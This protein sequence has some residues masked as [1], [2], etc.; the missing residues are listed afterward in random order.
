MF[1]LRG[2]VDWKVAPPPESYVKVLIPNVMVFGGWAFGQWLVHE[3]RALVM[4]LCLY[5]KRSL[6]DDLS[7]R[8][9]RSQQGDG[10]L[11]TRKR[12]LPG[13]PCQCLISE[14]DVVIITINL[15]FF[16][17]PHSAVFCYSSHNWLRRKT[18]GSSISAKHL[19]YKSTCFLPLTQPLSH[20]LGTQDACWIKPT[21]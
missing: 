5:K 20:Y 1:T 3:G 21:V 2:T 10:H 8:R 4:G 14:H 13:E 11:Q 9:V 15:Y 18:N 6:R 12:V 17:P 16:K 7:L 19:P